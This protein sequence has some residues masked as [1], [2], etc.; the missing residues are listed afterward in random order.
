MSQGEK[1]HD[2]VKNWQI[3]MYDL[4]WKWEVETKIYAYMYLY[5]HSK[6]V[7]REVTIGQHPH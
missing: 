5:M 6:N 1:K 2:I 4:A 7:Y 3:H